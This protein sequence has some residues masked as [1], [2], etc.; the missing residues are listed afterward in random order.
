MDTSF[1]EIL[2]IVKKMVTTEFLKKTHC[3]KLYFAMFL[4]LNC[5]R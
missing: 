2:Y 5:A 4:I 3:S 1:A